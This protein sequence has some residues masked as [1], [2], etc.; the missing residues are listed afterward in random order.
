MSR[1][2]PLVVLALMALPA[3][4]AAQQA[5]ARFDAA[6]FAPPSVVPTAEPTAEPTARDGSV[7][8]AR[9][10]ERS[11]LTRALHFVGGA[12]VGGWLGYVS[13]QVALSDWEK[14]TNSSFNEERSAWV[15]GGMIVGM[16]GSR[17]IGT[18]STP[19][20]PA[21][22]VQRPRG[23]RN[24]IEREQIASSGASSVYDLVTTLRREWLVTRGTNSMRESPRGAGGGIGPGA[25]MQVAPGKATVVVYMDDIELGPVETMRDILINDIM[26]IEFIEPREATYRYGSGHTHGVILL[27]TS[28]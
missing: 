11:F 23:E 21:V 18:T 8:D 27:K 22:D 13:S 10:S 14:E 7:T 15:A 26:E 17:L 3:A 28:L 16:L 2:L 20:R 1:S 12:V 9:A 24:V 6:R 4:T 19:R 25:S 5:A